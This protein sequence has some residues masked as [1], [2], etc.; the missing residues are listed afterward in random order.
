MSKSPLL[1]VSE[2]RLGNVR[3]WDVSAWFVK[4]IR[5]PAVVGIVGKATGGQSL[6]ATPE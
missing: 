3:V 1:L 5:D 6:P 2:V 4:S